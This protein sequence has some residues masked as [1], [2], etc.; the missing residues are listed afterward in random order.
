MQ[1]EIKLGILFLNA[2]LILCDWESYCLTSFS[3]F[4]L[5]ANDFFLTELF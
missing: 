5:G 2:A 1:F 4:M 3:S